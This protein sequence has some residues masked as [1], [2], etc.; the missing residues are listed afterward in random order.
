MA[1]PVPH[2]ILFYDYVDNI[3]ERRAPHREAHMAQ[4]RAAKDDGRILIAGPLGDP[5]H[6]AAIVFRN[7]AAARAFPENDP[8]VEAGLVTN[9]HVDLWSVVP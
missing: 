7:E 6:G 5:P 1:D 2:F 3:I 9:W 8:Y 4:I